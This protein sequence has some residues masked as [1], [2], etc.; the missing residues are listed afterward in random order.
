MDSFEEFLRVLTPEEMQEVQEM[1]VSPTERIF[2]HESISRITGKSIAPTKKREAFSP[3]YTYKLRSVLMQR[4]IELLAGN[5]EMEIL[6][7]F[8]RKGLRS[9]LLRYMRIVDKR[10]SAKLS[11]VE[12]EQFYKHLLHLS[13]PW[14]T[15]HFD[16][17]LIREYGRKWLDSRV[18]PE[19]EDEIY[20][21][22]M[23]YYYR[24]RVEVSIGETSA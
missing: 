12:R 9:H 11:G 5:N 13:F 24:I 2:L 18:D 4:A 15:C 21:K 8:E 6:H 17:S 16:E 7:F 10:L 20:I 19:P 23:I 14:L 3:E 1:K 22:A